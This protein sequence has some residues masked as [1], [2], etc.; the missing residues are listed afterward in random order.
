MGD[1]TVSERVESTST[2]RLFLCNGTQSYLG[3]HSPRGDRWQLGS[4]QGMCLRQMWGVQRN[5]LPEIAV[6][7]VSMV[8]NNQCVKGWHIL[9]PFIT[10]AGKKEKKNLYRILHNGHTSYRQWPLGKPERQGLMDGPCFWECTLPWCFLHKFFHFHLGTSVVSCLH[11]WQAQGKLG[12][13]SWKGGAA[14][15]CG[16]LC[17]ALCTQLHLL[18]LHSPICQK[19]HFNWTGCSQD[20]P[21]HTLIHSHPVPFLNRGRE[22]HQYLRLDAAPLPQHPFFNPTT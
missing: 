3:C 22:L 10:D 20:S 6:F 5:S 9:L 2:S 11:L 12:A 17:A 21:A 14:S 15:K 16:P 18:G 1:R 13:H 19:I 7:Q 8:Q 4:S